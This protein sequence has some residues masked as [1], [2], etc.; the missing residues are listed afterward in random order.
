MTMR[1]LSCDEGRRKK[2]FKKRTK[3]FRAKLFGEESDQE[4]PNGESN[5]RRGT[6][7]INKNQMPFVWKAP[8][9]VPKKKSK[10]LPN[11][12]DNVHG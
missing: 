10:L 5:G 7:R 1:K 3:N 2:M 12:V 11:S 4:Y 6:N 8:R 9:G